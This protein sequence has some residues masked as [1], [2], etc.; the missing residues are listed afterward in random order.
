M[1]R[2]EYLNI[3]NLPHR[4]SILEKKLLEGGKITPPRCKECGCDLIEV[5]KPLVEPAPCRANRVI[6]GYP[7][8]RRDEPYREGAKPCPTMVPLK[9][10]PSEPTL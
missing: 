6:C 8:G 7:C 9:K 3:Y 1:T 4:K 5:M 10:L 2:E